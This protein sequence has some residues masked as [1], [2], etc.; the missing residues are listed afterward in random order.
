MV[1][2]QIELEQGLDSYIFLGGNDNGKTCD[3]M[4]FEG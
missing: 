1:S 4:E 3:L 2:I